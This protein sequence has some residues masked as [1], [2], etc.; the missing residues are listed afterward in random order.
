MLE[1]LKTHISLDEALLIEAIKCESGDS[2]HDFQEWYGAVYAKRKPAQN[3]AALGALDVDAIHEELKMVK[4]AID[5]H[6]SLLT[7][8]RVAVLAGT[9]SM[10]SADVDALHVTIAN[11]RAN[12]PAIEAEY[13]RLLSE[14]QNRDG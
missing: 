1:A 8:H 13:A 11:L 14:E 10:S 6:E 2:R 3:Q 12:V 9:P 4:R 5:E 7:D